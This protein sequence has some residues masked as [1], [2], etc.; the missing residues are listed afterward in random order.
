MTILRIIFKINL[1]SKCFFYKRE[2]ISFRY[3]LLLCHRNFFFLLRCDNATWRLMAVVTLLSFHN[4]TCNT[5][6]NKVTVLRVQYNIILQCTIILLLL[7]L[8]IITT[9]I[10]LA[11]PLNVLLNFVS[12]LRSLRNSD[13]PQGGVIV[14]FIQSF[15]KYHRCFYFELWRAGRPLKFGLTVQ[16]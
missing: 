8:I 12:V 7:L 13:C 9:I 10:M 2:T 1:F 5:A 16:R 3:F 15:H 4:C 11:K 14:L 6:I